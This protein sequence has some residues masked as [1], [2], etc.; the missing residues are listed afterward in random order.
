MAWD[1]GLSILTPEEFEVCIPERLL[2][3]CRVISSKVGSDEFSLLCKFEIRDGKAVV[4]DEFYIPEQEVSSASVD[5][6]E[7]V[8]IKREKEGFNCIIHKHP[9]GCRAFSS[10]DNDTINSHFPLSILFA[11]GSFVAAV[12]LVETSVGLMRFQ[13]GRITVVEE[14]LPEVDVSRIKKKAYKFDY[15][16]PGVVPLT[17]LPKKKKKKKKRKSGG[18]GLEEI[19]RYSEVLTDEE[20]DYMLRDY[21]M[22]K[23]GGDWGYATLLRQAH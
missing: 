20:L 6:L 1:S 8:S 2:K 14:G 17:Q 3:V 22:R 23:H 11:D 10:S 7:D 9:S 18:S 12:I 15:S 21:I 13:V 19:Y 5:F 16:I 4:S